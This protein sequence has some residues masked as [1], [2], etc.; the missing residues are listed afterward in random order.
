[1]ASRAG[2]GL[3][4]CSLVAQEKQL[5]VRSVADVVTAA[6]PFACME[7]DRQWLSALLIPC[8]LPLG[9]IM[10]AKLAE[11]CADVPQDQ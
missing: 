10:P 1:M 11:A 5:T 9:I 7:R 2:S 3:T 4:S 6:D 8:A